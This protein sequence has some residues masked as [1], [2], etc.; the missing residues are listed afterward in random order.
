VAGSSRCRPNRD[1]CSA[2]AARAGVFMSWLRRFFRGVYQL[3]VLI[4]NEPPG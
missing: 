2:L 4:Y 1:G 3:L